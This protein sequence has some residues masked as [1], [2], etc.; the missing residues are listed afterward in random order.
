MLSRKAPFEEL[1]L[2]AYKEKWDWRLAVFV[3]YTA[4]CASIVYGLLEIIIG[5]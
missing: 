2:R 1:L 4:T 3:I 5:A